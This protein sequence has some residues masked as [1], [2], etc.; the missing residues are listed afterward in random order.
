MKANCWAYRDMSSGMIYQRGW[1]IKHA[2]PAVWQPVVENA[3]RGCD[4]SLLIALTGGRP[5][6]R[7]ARFNAPLTVKELDRVRVSIE[8]GRP[9]GAENWVQET[10]R[11]LGVEQAVRTEGRPR[12]AS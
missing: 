5:T 12:K 9:Y 3:R 2:T 4:Q 7:T 11:D 8:R 6:N 10:V 1:S